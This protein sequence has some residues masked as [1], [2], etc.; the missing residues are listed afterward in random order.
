M[1]TSEANGFVYYS[2][3]FC[4]W[5]NLFAWTESLRRRMERREVARDEEEN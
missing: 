5:K 4:R 1:A 2:K 3:V